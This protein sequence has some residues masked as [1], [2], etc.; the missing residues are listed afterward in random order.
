M[1]IFA[2]QRLQQWHLQCPQRALITHESDSDI[3]VAEY[4]DERVCVSVHE[5]ISET[6][7]DLHKVMFCA[8]YLGSGHDSVLHGRPCD[9]TH[10]RFHG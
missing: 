2:Q 5:H 6:S 9:V 3:R 7:S 4:C 1:T 8:C 10:F